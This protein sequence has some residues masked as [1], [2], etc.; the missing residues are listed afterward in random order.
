[1]VYG[2]RE[3]IQAALSGEFTCAVIDIGMP[4]IGGREV[5]TALRRFPKTKD[6][7][8]IALSGWGTDADIKK[9]LQ[10]GFDVHLTKPVQHEALLAALKLQ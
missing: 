4:G 10:A 6:M 9:N 2:G 1:V 7:R 8:L 3:A 5:A